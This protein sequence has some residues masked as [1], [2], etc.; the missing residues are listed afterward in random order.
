MPGDKLQHSGQDQHGRVEWARRTPKPDL[1]EVGKEAL[2]GFLVTGVA[3]AVGAGFE[4]EALI[5]GVVGGI[6]T[7]ILWY[8]WRVGGRFVFAPIQQRL[9]SANAWEQEAT[10]LRDRVKQLENARPSLGLMRLQQEG[11]DWFFEVHNTGALGTFYA[12]Y[13]VVEAASYGGP[14]EGR[15]VE[16][17]WEGA[18]SRAATIPQGL[19]RRLHIA[20]LER[21]P[22]G[23]LGRVRLFYSGAQGQREAIKQAALIQNGVQRNPQMVLRLTITSH[24]AFADGEYTTELWVNLDGL[25]LHPV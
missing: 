20:R 3:F 17:W 21:A 18:N 1:E 6:L 5:A 8:A 24:P 12:Q 14:T 4:V 13:R 25:T 16:G 19:F 7:P 9:A 23:A 2:G 15:L 10:T 11:E 22:D